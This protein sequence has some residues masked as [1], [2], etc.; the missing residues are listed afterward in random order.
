M[1]LFERWEYQSTHYIYKGDE[2]N[3]LSKEE[4]LDLIVDKTLTGVDP[5]KG[6]LWMHHSKDGTFRVTG[7]HENYGKYWL[8]GN[9]LCRTYKKYPG[10]VDYVFFYR[11]ADGSFEDKNEYHMFFTFLGTLPVSVEK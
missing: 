2:K 1:P 4:V 10:H 6:Q 5:E 9:K 11:N 8:E 3:I 7:S